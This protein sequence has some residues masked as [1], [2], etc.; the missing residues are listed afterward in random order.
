MTEHDIIAA[1][2]R[3]FEAPLIWTG[4]IILFIV[5]F[6]KHRPRWDLYQTER[7]SRWAFFSEI[8]W[9]IGAL[10]WLGV[11]VAVCASWGT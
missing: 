9:W 11:M 6:G 2:W 10:F 1:F 7:G 4:E 3:L 5:S 8:S